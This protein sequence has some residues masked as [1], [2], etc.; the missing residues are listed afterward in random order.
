MS[1]LKG[2]TS[3]ITIL[4]HSCLCSRES[5]G[6]DFRVV[7]GQHNIITIKKGMSHC[8]KAKKGCLQL[9]KSVNYVNFGE[10]MDKIIQ[11]IGWSQNNVRNAFYDD[12]TLKGS[13]NIFVYLS[14][15][16]G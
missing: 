6:W 14:D 9:S 16:G 11:K 12:P 4:T 8:L 15:K 13:R 2:L 10:I 5:R 7:R 1:F 3:R